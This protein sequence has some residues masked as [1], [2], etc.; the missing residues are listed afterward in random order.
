MTVLDALSDLNVAFGGKA[1]PERLAIYVERLADLPEAQVIDGIER[2]MVSRTEGWMP[3]IGEIRQAATL[4]GATLDGA[5]EL[6]WTE[7]QQEVRRVGYGT[8]RRL[9]GGVWHDPEQPRF[10]SPI[11]E[12]AVRSVTWK[13]ICQ[14]D[15]VKVRESFL[16]T[17]RHLSERAIGQAVLGQAV[18]LL[19][20]TAPA[21]LDEGDR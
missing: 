20:A 18:D 6:A 5:A 2:L 13:S 7:V 21:M 8:H 14:D 11:T 17:W 12:A 4:G 16:W 1:T 9:I 10:S 3:T 19:P 15:S